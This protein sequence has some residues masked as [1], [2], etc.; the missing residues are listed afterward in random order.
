MVFKC[1]TASHARSEGVAD[2]SDTQ[3]IERQFEVIEVQS[4]FHFG[5]DDIVRLDDGFFCI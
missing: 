2:R 5:E 1:A 3:D 4:S